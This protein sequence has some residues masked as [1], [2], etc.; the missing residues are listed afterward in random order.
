MTK[1]TTNNNKLSGIKSKLAAAVC[2][3]LVA[4]I[5]V[6]SSTYAWFTLSTAP[7]VTGITTAV[8]ANGALEIALLPESGNLDDITTSMNSAADATVKNVTWGNLIDL[9]K[10]E[11]YGLDKITLYPSS[12][13]CENDENGNASSFSSLMLSVPTYGADGRVDTLKPS[14][15]TSVFKNGAF[16]INDLYGVRAVGVSS[17]MSDRQLAYRD[18]RSKASTAMATAKTLASTSLSNNG[19]ALANIAIKHAAN[20]GTTGDR[21]TQ[22]EINSL[23]AIVN[24]LLGT[25]D[26]GVFGYIE[27]ATMQYIVAFTA[28]GYK[29]SEATE[30]F[31]KEAYSLVQSIVNS[32]DGSLQTFMTE[33]DENTTLSGYGLSSTKLKELLPEVASVYT[34]LYGTDETDGAVEKATKALEQLQNITVSSSTQIDVNGTATDACKWSAIKDPLNCLVNTSNME[35]NDIPVSDI[36]ARMSDLINSV[37]GKGLTVTMP[38]GGGVYADVA[39]CC[40]DYTAA[41]KIKEVSYNGMTLK[42]MDARMETASTVNPSYLAELGSDI[43]SYGSPAAETS[44]DAQNP[45]SEFYGYVIDLAFRTNASESNLL[46]QTTGKD[47]IYSDNTNDSTMGNGSTMTFRSTSAA[48][49]N[50]QVV[51]LMSN[52]RIVFFTPDTDRNTVLATAKLDTA[53]T[54]VDAEGNITANIYLYKNEYLKDAT[55]NYLKYTDDEKTTEILYWYFN[56]KY[57]DADPSVGGNTANEVTEAQMAGRVVTET[58]MTETSD[59]VITAL[60]QNQAQKVSVLV[61]LDG[62]SIEN[63]D[64][65]SSVATSMTGSMNLQFS[66]SANLVPMEYADLHITGATTAPSASPSAAPSEEP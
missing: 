49:T 14:T 64:V 54:T 29:G 3:L 35:V 26:K 37:A 9:S 16:A 59:A 19:N 17:G 51:D 10:V 57:Y 63:S 43:T 32:S 53:N 60:A 46:L 21:Y 22:A 25:T 55:G 34:S 56:G 36:K 23:I 65:A 13:N 41:I 27:E 1:E 20:D 5:M 66:S 28:S 58:V 4:V 48:F 47:R 6:V 61:Y 2:M 12:L 33:L 30:V 62:N 7:E 42:N 18:A 24:D 45:I 31:P 15:S 50:Q 11:F 8:G 40:G 44:E 39:D 38:T 52:F